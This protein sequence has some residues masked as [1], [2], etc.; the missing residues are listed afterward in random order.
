MLS[1]VRSQW[2]KTCY[3]WTR[4]EVRVTLLAKTFVQVCAQ[5][6][7]VAQFIA[8]SQGPIP[9]PSP[10]PIPAEGWEGNICRSCGSKTS[11]P[12]LWYGRWTNHVSVKNI[13]SIF[14]AMSWLKSV[15]TTRASFLSIPST[16]RT[17]REKFPCCS[18]HCLLLLSLFFFSQ[19]YRSLSIGSFL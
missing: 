3:E 13:S 12:L 17:G 1:P 7:Y 4:G 14:S 8:P 10:A 2:L 18:F 19:R 16:E 11:W 15:S 9:I 5:N 6:Y